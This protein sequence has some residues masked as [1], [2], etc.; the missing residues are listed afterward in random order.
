M[1]ST[2]HNNYQ[3]YMIILF[4]EKDATVKVTTQSAN[5]F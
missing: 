5:Q 3:K 4:A 1:Y 2:Q